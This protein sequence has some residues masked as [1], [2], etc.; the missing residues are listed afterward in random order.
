VRCDT[1]LAAISA[2]ADHEP[3]GVRARGLADHLAEC[4]R[5]R[6]FERHV[7]GLRAS[8]RFEQVAAA[9]DIAAAVLA[10]LPV[11]NGVPQTEHVGP[12][13]ARSGPRRDRGRTRRRDRRSLAVVAAAAAVAG[14]VAGATFVGIGTDPHDPAAADIP[15]QVLTAQL[16]IATLDERFDLVEHGRPDHA[17]PRRFAGRLA[18]ASPESLALT[19]QERPDP[20]G[21]HRGADQP[22]SGGEPVRAGDVRLL[23]SGGRWWLDAPRLCSPGP[24]AG[25][26][27]GTMPWSRAVGGREPFSD[28]SPLPLELVNPV[29]SFTLASA[30]PVLGHRTV[31]GHDAVGVAV[32]AAQV[33][34]VLEGLSP[35]GDLRAVHP[36][37]PV[38]LW[39]DREH[40]VPLALVARAAPGEARARWAAAN[41]YDDRPGE[42]VVEMTVTSVRINE[43]VDPAAFDPPDGTGTQGLDDGFDDGPAPAAPVPGELPAG[44][45]A[46]RSGTVSAPGGPPVDV[47]SWTDGRAWLKVRATTSWSGTRLFGELGADVRVVD[48]G[49]AGRGYANADGSRVAV[50]GDGVEVVVSGSVSPATLQAVAASLGVVGR[51]VP[52]SWQDATSASLAQAAEAMPNLLVAPDLAGFGPP[53]VTLTTT[54]VIQNHAGPG[55]RGFVLTQDLS[56]HLAPPSGPDAVAVDMRETTGRYNQ[57]RGELEWVEGGSSH[58]LRSPTLTLAELLDIADRLEAR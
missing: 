10:S 58:S 50:H 36:S 7:A 56:P 15:A 14:A 52:D 48:L 12:R 3:T 26:Q 44:F 20:G 37:D 8:L 45:G 22:G 53:A 32:A 55:N 4:P 17:G 49:G 6:D 23:A 30:P 24:G 29:D 38:E 1:A 13:P 25:C 16:D 54:S 42:V 57:E 43:G 11:R 21:E 35:A 2:A 31:A 51:R 18:Y 5:C 41:G 19:V 34:P 27:D 40:L 47:R 39:L 33:G 9:P 28:A 46:H